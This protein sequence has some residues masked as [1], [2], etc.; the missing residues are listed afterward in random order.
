MTPNR[1]PDY[2]F[3]CGVHYTNDLWEFAI[4][5]KGKKVPSITFSL[6]NP[7]IEAIEKELRKLWITEGLPVK[8]VSNYLFSQYERKIQ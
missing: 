5:E 2:E 3:K 1:P 7:T 4:E 8:P 6:K